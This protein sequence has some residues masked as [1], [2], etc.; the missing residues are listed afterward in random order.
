MSRTTL[1]VNALYCLHV[2]IIYST[3]LVTI[4]ALEERTLPLDC[5]SKV[6]VKFLINVTVG[7][8]KKPTT[9]ILCNL[10]LYT[11]VGGACAVGVSILKSSCKPYTSLSAHHVW[12]CD[13]FL[14]PKW[15]R[16]RGFWKARLISRHFSFDIFNLGNMQSSVGLNKCL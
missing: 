8:Q 11:C 5:G 10:K 6:R 12:R 3:A 7:S 14:P 9:R 4:P 13:M 15:R 16:T 2:N 1:A